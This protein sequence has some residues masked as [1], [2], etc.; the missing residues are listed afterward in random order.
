M[1][2]ELHIGRGNP[3]EPMAHGYLWEHPSPEVKAVPRDSSEYRADLNRR[4]RQAN[5]SECEEWSLAERGWRMRAEE[6][7]DALRRYPGDLPLARVCK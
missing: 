6:Q 3:L 7:A 2:G 1:Y 4:L 5:L